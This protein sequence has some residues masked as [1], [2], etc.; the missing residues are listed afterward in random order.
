MA[1]LGS[2]AKKVL[3]GKDI[4]PKEANLLWKADLDELI[5]WANRVRR[6]FKGDTVHLC[7]IIN[8]KSG[9]CSENCSFCAQSGHHKTGAPRY[10]LVTED[11]ISGAFDRAAASGA[12][13]FGVITS[14]RAVTKKEV[15]KI[16]AAISRLKK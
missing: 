12:R 7:S 6:K 15:E 1:K 13:C 3:G 4:T 10:P 8:A 16:G 5:F 9:A 14:G 2:I 11:R